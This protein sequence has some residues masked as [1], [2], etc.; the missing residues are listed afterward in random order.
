MVR[1]LNLC[2]WVYNETLALRKNAWENDQKSTS[3]Y[4][5]H[6]LLTT[7]KDEKT[8]LKDVF[9][10]VLQNVQEMVDLAIPGSRV[11]IDTV[12]S[13]ILSSDSSSN[14]VSSI[15]PR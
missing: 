14:L 5:T 15:Y 2:Q 11:R 8:E 9:S 13:P 6:N 12:P 3:K 10:Q 1:A 4:K 7:W